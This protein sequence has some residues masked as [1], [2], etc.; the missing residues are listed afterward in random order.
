MSANNVPNKIE[1]ENIFG[2]MIIESGINSINEE[3]QINQE[4]II[5]YEISTFENEKHKET[6]FLQTKFKK[7]KNRI[8]QKVEATNAQKIKTKSALYLRKDPKSIKNKNNKI[9]EDSLKLSINN[10]IDQSN[11]SFNNQIKENQSPINNNFSEKNDDINKNELIIN[12][13]A[14]KENILNTNENDPNNL[15]IEMIEEENKKPSLTWNTTNDPDSPFVPMEYIND[16]WDS[17]IEKEKL[18]F[19][20]YDEIITNQT[21]IKESMRCILIDWLISLQNKFF[22]NI[23]TLFLTVNLI[24]RYLSKKPILRTRFQLLGVTAL[25][26]ASKYEEMYMKNINDYVEITARAFNKNQILEM[27]SELIDLI[28]FNLDLPLSIDFLGLLGSMYKFN[29]AEF[30]LSYFLLEAYLFTL[31]SCKYKQSQISLA[32]C[33]IILGL[34]KINSICPIQ[35]TN[36]IKYYSDLFKINFEIWK[37]YELIIE[38]GKNVYNF[39]EKSD[40]VI[41]KEVYIIFK[42]LFV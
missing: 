22:S 32:V 4:N 6:N 19:Y 14:N 2:N 23:K 29:K 12:N 3:K 38:C 1:K 39:Y 26:I 25:F 42:D 15:D 36:F 33:Y 28:D 9:K 8:K 16:I 21:D 11:S 17:F 34:R 41:Y 30:R 5:N 7:H 20:S 31:N 37:E 13:L 40:Q 35:E 10:K 24:D 18:N 27:E